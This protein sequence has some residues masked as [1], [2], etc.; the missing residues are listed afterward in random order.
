[1]PDMRRQAL[2][3]FASRASGAVLQ[4][5]LLILVAR[6][7]TPEEFGVMNA[8]VGCFMFLGVV[9]DLGLT[10]FSIRAY[11]I[12]ND[13]DAALAA[14]ALQRLL[15]LGFFA[16]ATG[17]LGI[18]WALEILPP[19]WALGATAIVLW[20]TLE[21]VCEAESAIFIARASVV[22]P[23]VSII[24]RRAV[25]VLV[26]LPSIGQLPPI[27]AFG[28]SVIAGGAVGYVYLLTQRGGRSGAPVEGYGRASLIRAAI[29]FGVSNIFAQT[30]NLD[31]AAVAL[32]SGAAAS[33]AYG[34]S[35]RLASPIFLVSSAVAS[36]VMPA[37]ASSGPRIARR[38]V[39]FG[40]FAGLGALVI[41]LSLLPISGQIMKLVFGEAYA[42][43]G[44]ILVTVVC[45]TVMNSLISPFSAVL[46]A[47]GLA[48]LV[49][50]VSSVFGVGV[51]SAIFGGALLLGAQGAALGYLAASTLSAILL[52]SFAWRAFRSDLEDQS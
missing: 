15:S 47:K 40:L 18:G 48:A 5:L 44:P 6:F 37:I 14:V 24:V 13:E 10:N 12:D 51:I 45:A 17:I 41:S 2:W 7:I 4:A 16:I 26:F 1:L 9:S 38:I 30:R 29:A 3:I 20:V 23:A 34:A 8:F 22:Q 43:A 35:S 50:R 28:L 49:A 42:G 36:S 31:G 39:V 46:Q 25:S 32:A 33:G 21:K 11:A 19:M 27:L 52:G